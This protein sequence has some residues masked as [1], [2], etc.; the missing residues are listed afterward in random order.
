[1]TIDEALAR[2]TVSVPEAGAV[3]FGL[4][5]QAA[6]DA[7]KRGDIPT[8]RIGGRIVVPVAPLAQ[9][10]GLRSTIGTAA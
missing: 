2:A 4:A 8:I 10:L 7:A 9:K 5:R 3:F 6:Y 1:M